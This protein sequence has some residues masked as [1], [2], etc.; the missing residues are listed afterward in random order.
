MS[1]SADFWASR[2]PWRRRIAVAA[3]ALVVLAALAV[4]LRT[5]AGGDVLRSL[6]QTLTAMRDT[7]LVLIQVLVLAVLAFMLLAIVL[8]LSRG[9]DKTHLLPFVNATADPS[10]VAV[11]ESLLS[12][13]QWIL[14]IH[15]RS[16]HGITAEHVSATTIDPNGD[17]LVSSLGNVGSIGF[18]P[19]SISVGQLLL[20]MKGL[21]P[22]GDRRTV[23][24][25]SVQ[26][27]GNTTRLVA[28]LSRG[29]KDMALAVEAPTR[30]GDELIGLIKDLAYRV[31]YA[32]PG[33]SVEAK[34]WQSFRA[35]TEARASY[36]AYVDLPDDAS[37]DAALDCARRAHQAD[38][39]NK[40]L[41]GLFFN[42]GNAFMTADRIDVAEELFRTANQI[43][44]K[45]LDPYPQLA[46]CLYYRDRPTDAAEVLHQAI[47]I[48][49]SNPLM[50]YLLGL[51][52]QST[53]R[54]DQAGDQIQEALRLGY[55]PVAEARVSL[56]ALALRQGDRGRWR[57]IIG[58]VAEAQL[59]TSYGL[60]C[61][62][63]V[64]EDAERSLDCLRRAM[65]DE[66]VP[67]AHVERDPDLAYVRADA[68]F[69]KLV[70]GGHGA[71]TNG[72]ARPLLEEA[73]RC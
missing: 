30:D 51:M 16:L 33:A 41:Y 47:Q 67:A 1:P 58:Q 3:L 50:H 12:E 55:Q 49:P 66:Q 32:I 25:G 21:W 52:E 11:D 45:E 54:L 15:Q 19:S 35:F 7:L 26:R 38:P 69:R 39:D 46:L 73:P 31:H 59:K 34:T 65:A 71:A 68:R 62:W 14:E 56:A 2:R 43:E 53:G 70:A 37:R 29:R 48:A 23:I 27:Y 61:Y 18:G 22:W 42:L 28:R 4:W 9:D 24:A 10:L 5:P 40:R 44:P 20:V 36:A 13:L 60:A 8:W 57:E 63:S 72:S 6:P 64:A 17:D